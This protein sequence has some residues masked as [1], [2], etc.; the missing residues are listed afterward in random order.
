MM[1]E[2]SQRMIIIRAIIGLVFYCPLWRFNVWII[3]QGL[4]ELGPVGKLLFYVNLFYMF[5]NWFLIAKRKSEVDR[6]TVKFS[7]FIVLILVIMELPTWIH[8]F[9]K[10]QG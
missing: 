8:V 3:N 1:A 9:Y 6:E 4:Y 7:L 10:G 5:I 2:N